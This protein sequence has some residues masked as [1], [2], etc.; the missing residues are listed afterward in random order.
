MVDLSVLS[1]EKRSQRIVEEVV[2]FK[3]SILSDIDGRYLVEVTD[4]VE[5]V[6]RWIHRYSRDSKLSRLYGSLFKALSAYS[7]RLQC[8]TQTA[9]LDRLLIEMSGAL[10]KPLH[11]R[12][13]QA[14][15]SKEQDP[16]QEEELVQTKKDTTSTSD[17]PLTLA[18]S[19]SD[20]SSEP[21][22]ESESD[23]EDEKEAIGGSQAAWNSI[24][25]AIAKS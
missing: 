11:P 16:T 9:Q 6:V 20:T 14:K 7:T 25:A 13:I 5:K 4:A 1:V 15:T 22:S 18:T 21:D 3:T 2:V 23:S 8:E 12:S 10:L 19:D 24:M 17:A